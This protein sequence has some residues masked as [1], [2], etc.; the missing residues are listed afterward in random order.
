MQQIKEPIF[1]YLGTDNGDHL[2][3]IRCPVIEKSAS[4]FD[5]VLDDNQS[6]QDNVIFNYGIIIRF[7]PENLFVMN[8]SSQYVQMEIRHS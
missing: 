2:L 4:K 1:E 7:K 8:K 5:F 3:K 6:N